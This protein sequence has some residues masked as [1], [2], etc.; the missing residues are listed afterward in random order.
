MPTSYWSYDTCPK[1]YLWPLIYAGKVLCVVISTCQVQ[2]QSA[3]ERR[4]GEIGYT[5]CTYGVTAH[6]ELLAERSQKKITLKYVWGGTKIDYRARLSQVD[7]V[8]QV[9]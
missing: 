4:P 1:A 3:G 9:G 8:V 5:P 2:D 6:G 7:D